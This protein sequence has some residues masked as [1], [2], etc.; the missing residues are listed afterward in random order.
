MF[1]KFYLTKKIEF[2]KKIKGKV[3]QNRHK[4]SSNKVIR[5][6]SQCRARIQNKSD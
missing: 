3:V 5:N 2:K 4:C 1:Q 6:Y